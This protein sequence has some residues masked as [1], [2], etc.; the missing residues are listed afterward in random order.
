MDSVAPVLPL[1]MWTSSCFE[2]GD[3]LKEDQLNKGN[4]KPIKNL[5]R[6]NLGP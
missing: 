6:Y 1:Q 4:N 5:S 3:V 2:N